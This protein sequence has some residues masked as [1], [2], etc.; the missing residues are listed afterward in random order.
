MAI[1]IYAIVENEVVV[2]MTAAEPSHAKN[3]PNW[4]DVETS[5]VAGVGMGW[6]YINGEFVA[7]VEDLDLAWAEVRKERDQLLTNCDWVVLKAKE[8][9]TNIPTSWKTYRQELRDIT[10]TFSSPEEVVFPEPPTA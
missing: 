2:N 9:G 3:Y 1:K 8:C 4:V 6:S 10:T 7:P 5:T